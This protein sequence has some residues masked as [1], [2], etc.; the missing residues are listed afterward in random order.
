MFKSNRRQFLAVSAALSGGASAAVV[1]ALPRD[2]V[3]ED[4]RTYIGFGAKQAG[5]AGDMKCGAWLG[6]ELER[7]GFKVERQSFSA[8]F[9]EPARCSLSCGGA[10]ATLWPQPIVVQ[11]GPSGVTGPLVRI[12]RFGLADGPLAGSI[13]LVDLPY[14]RWSSATAKAIRDPVAAAF[15]AGARGVVVITNGPTGRIIALNADGRNPMFDGP[16]ALLAPDDAGLFL[17]AA[18]RHEPATLVVQGT[19]GRRPAY[20]LIGRIDRAKPR[21]LVVSTPRSGWYGCAGE[22]GPGIAIWLWL[23]R[24]SS[25]AVRDHNLAFVCNSGHEYEYLGAAEALRQVAPRPADTHFWLHLGAGIAAR[26]WHELPGKWFPL[27]SVDPQRF[28]SL[29]PSLLPLAR[30]VFAGHAGYEA[31]YASDVLAAGELVEIMSAGYANVAGVFGSHRYHHV[32]ED[33]KR[34]VS[35]ESVAATAEA[36]QRFV[37]EIV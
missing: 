35:A 13:A 20:N 2:S 25:A 26:D 31:P 30:R 7:L 18:A 28:L 4:L 15:K 33:D 27:P 17:A 24:W 5:G 16:V 36:F 21:W 6:G 10:S 19:G 12:D 23:A 37:A 22:R 11:T 9:F 1:P 34:C 8:P 14:G 3:A 32:A 29:S